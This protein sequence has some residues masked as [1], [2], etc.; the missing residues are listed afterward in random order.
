MKDIV[1]MFH[2]K[3]KK[4]MQILLLF[5]RHSILI[6]FKFFRYKNGANLFILSKKMHKGKM[7]TRRLAT[8]CRGTASNVTQE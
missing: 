4:D 6:F 8:A 1:T 3:V 7:E 2:H 5:L